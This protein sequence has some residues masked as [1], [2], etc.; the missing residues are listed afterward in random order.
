ME[1]KIFYIAYKNS[2]YVCIALYPAHL[3]KM[4]T[5]LWQYILKKKSRLGT[6]E[7]HMTHTYITC[8]FIHMYIFACSHSSTKI[9]GLV[10]KV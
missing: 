4:A 7:T 6:Y 8:T 9:P 2:S 10:D 1:N 5:K 3:F